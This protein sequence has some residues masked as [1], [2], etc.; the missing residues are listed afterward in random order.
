MP[1]SSSG[2]R[3]RAAFLPAT[4]G[5]PFLPV[6]VSP[7]TSPPSLRS[8]RMAA[9]L[10]PMLFHPSGQKQAPL[11]QLP[12]FTD[13]SF[14]VQL[15]CIP[16]Y[17]NNLLTISFITV[18][19]NHRGEVFFSTPYNNIHVDITSLSKNDGS[20]FTV[21][22]PTSHVHLFLSGGAYARIQQGKA[23]HDHAAGRHRADHGLLLP[24]CRL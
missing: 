12:P 6:S 13:F 17:K 21:R 4:G 9:L 1:S 3:L 16:P 2:R 14:R 24:R 15:Y 5:F 18:F 19:S 22:F 20:C 11:P 8:L 23:V 10:R 7:G